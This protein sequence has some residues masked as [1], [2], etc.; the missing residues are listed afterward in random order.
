MSSVSGIPSTTTAVYKLWG[1]YAQKDP[2]YEIICFYKVSS[3]EALMRQVGVCGDIVWALD[4]PKPVH[5]SVDCS[6]FTTC[7]NTSVMT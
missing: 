5:E 2:S 6:V 3:G 1:S 7:C 4:L